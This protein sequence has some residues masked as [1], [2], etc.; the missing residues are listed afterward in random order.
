[1]I[2]EHFGHGTVRPVEYAGTNMISVLFCGQTLAIG[3]LENDLFLL[4]LELN[5]TT[6]RIKIHSFMTSD[7]FCFENY[8]LVGSSFGYF[9]IDL[10][11]RELVDFPK[12]KNGLSGLISKIAV[13]QEKQD[14]FLFC[15]V[16][17]NKTILHLD[18]S[19]HVSRGKLDADS[20]RSQ[21]LGNLKKKIDQL[22]NIDDTVPQLKNKIPKRRQT[23]TE[24]VKAEGPRE[25][26]T[27]NASQ[28]F[29]ANQKGFSELTPTQQKP[30]ANFT[31]KS[32]NMNQIGT[33]KTSNSE[34]LGVQKGTDYNEQN[35][36]RL[37]ATLSEQRTRIQTLHDR[38]NRYKMRVVSQ[39]ALV[40]KLLAEKSNLE[41]H[42]E[43]STFGVSQRQQMVEDLLSQNQIM[44]REIVTL[45]S[46]VKASEARDKSNSGLTSELKKYA[47]QLKSE[48]A[49]QVD[50]VSRMGRQV[51][52]L[53]AR[54]RQA[55]EEVAAE[56]AKVSRLRKKL[57]DLETANQQMKSKF[58]SALQQ[59]NQ[60][61][62]AH[63]KQTILKLVKQ[64]QSETAKLLAVYK[65]KLQNQGTTLNKCEID[66]ARLTVE[67]KTPKRSGR[68][69]KR[70]PRK[71]A[72]NQ[73][74]RFKPSWFRQARRLSTKTTN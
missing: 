47:K 72:T 20:G 13:Y 17:Q 34:T 70:L 54:L 73:N 14:Y 8:L 48:L 4:D 26:K 32:K 16:E 29:L 65:Q 30:N 31:G 74:K 53:K 61:H 71:P 33:E 57:N 3:T 27:C 46:H 51:E 37:L 67:K 12:F 45:K 39:D 11:K 24:P 10:A 55:T 5:Q 21:N 56:Q 62:A 15:T 58:T 64:S 60:K 28:T 22:K 42:C 19:E 38:V 36:H 18:I 9:A 23:K 43:K 40:E 25:L 49:R 63:L 68:I 66:W 1:M 35:Q 50:S 44:Q 6:R 69:S 7:L 59:N 52:N 41:S 2:L